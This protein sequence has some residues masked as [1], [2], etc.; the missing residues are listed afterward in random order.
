MNSAAPNARTRANRAFVVR[1]VIGIALYVLGLLLADVVSTS[2]VLA[3]LPA[4]LI[5]PGIGFIAWANIEMY[6]SG[7][8]F[9]RRKI[10]EAILLAFLIATPLI[11]AV[12]V[13]QFSVLPEVNWIFAFTILM[14]SWIVGTIV[15][16]VRY[17]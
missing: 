12:G 11:L 9:E 6:R 16:A 4:L 17:R 10:A 15:S 5:L 2:G 8:E 14:V 3:W 13:L 7:D 1:F